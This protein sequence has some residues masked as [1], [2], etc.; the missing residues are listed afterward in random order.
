MT[1]LYD[2]VEDMLLQLADNSK[3][4][5]EIVRTLAGAI[6][7]VDEQLLREV[8]NVAVQHEVRREAILGELQTLASHLCALPAKGMPSSAR[9]A[10][11]QK[12]QAR[13]AVTAGNDHGS[14]N[15][16]DWRQAAKNIHDDLD[17]TIEPPNPTH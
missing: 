16:A 7:R 9:Y 5:L 13:N 6:R 3:V 15:G 14:S 1:G 12:A 8:R 17:F 4:E 11:D 2:N 10:I